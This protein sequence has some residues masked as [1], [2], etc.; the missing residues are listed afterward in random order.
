MSATHP[1]MPP[2]ADHLE[3]DAL[4]LGEIRT[5]AI[6]YDEALV[7]RGRWPHGGGVH[8]HLGGHAGDEQLGDARVGQDVCSSVA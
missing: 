3:A 6:G 8:A 4:E 2:W 5:D 1:K 7:T